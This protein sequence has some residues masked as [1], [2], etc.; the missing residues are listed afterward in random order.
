MS[1]LSVCEILYKL[2]ENFKSYNFF[3]DIPLRKV[4]K[5]SKGVTLSTLGVAPVDFIPQL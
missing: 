2:L 4:S 5:I 1:L 3:L